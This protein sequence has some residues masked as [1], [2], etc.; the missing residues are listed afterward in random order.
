[1]RVLI[2]VKTGGRYKQAFFFAGDYYVGPDDAGSS[3]LISFERQEGN[4]IFIGYELFQP[5][6]LPC[7]PTGG[8]AVVRFH[9][10]GTQLK[11]LDPIPARSVR[12]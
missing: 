3:S 1:L 7:C 6:D 10:D 12:G 9:W 2:A 4:T 11:A 8:K 5:K